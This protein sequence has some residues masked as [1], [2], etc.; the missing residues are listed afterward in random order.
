MKNR[1]SVPIISLSRN[2]SIEK[3]SMLLSENSK[4]RNPKCLAQDMHIHTRNTMRKEV[5]FPS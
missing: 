5:A 2:K 4:Y 1:K 3:Q